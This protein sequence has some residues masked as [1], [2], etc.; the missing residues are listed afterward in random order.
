MEPS[1]STSEADPPIGERYATSFRASAPTGMGRRDAAT[2]HL[3]VV[4]RSSP[5]RAFRIAF[6]RPMKRCGA[7]SIAVAASEVADRDTARQATGG[8]SGGPGH[9]VSV[10]AIDQSS[11]SVELGLRKAFDGYP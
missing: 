8:Q 7:V 9:Q 1:S 2:L 5:P 6:V 4:E 11:K 3:H 10:S